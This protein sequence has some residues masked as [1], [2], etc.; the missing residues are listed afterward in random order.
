LR[1]Q[2]LLGVRNTLVGGLKYFSG[3]QILIGVKF[4][5]GRGQKYFIE[6]SN[7]IGGQKYFNEGANFKYQS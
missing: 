2:I 6:R 7:F 5:K 3:G 4:F 1:G